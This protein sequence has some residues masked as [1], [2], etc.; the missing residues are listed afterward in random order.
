MDIEQFKKLSTSK[1]EAGRKTRPVKNELK[2]Y[3][4]A[5][6]DAYEGVSEIYKPI[7]DV[8]KSVKQSIDKKQD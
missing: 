4:Q 6:Q 8:E 5:K 1:I 2:E 3:K 7:I